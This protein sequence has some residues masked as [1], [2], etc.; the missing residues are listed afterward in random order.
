MADFDE[1]EFAASGAENEFEPDE[2]EGELPGKQTGGCGA[3][4]VGGKGRGKGKGKGSA[5]R[6][7]KAKGKH[8]SKIKNGMKHCPG[9][10]HLCFPARERHVQ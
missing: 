4:K 8:R 5:G 1:D 3:G 10:A 9:C 7:G 2:Q 6:G